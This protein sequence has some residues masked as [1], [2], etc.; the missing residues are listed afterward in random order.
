MSGLTSQKQSGAG[1]AKDPSV[2]ANLV[3]VFPEFGN[4][5]RGIAEYTGHCW[6]RES[7]TLQY[8]SS[9]ALCGR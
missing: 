7:R 1:T 6:R 5:L 8:Q 9:G 2:V 3:C 4:S